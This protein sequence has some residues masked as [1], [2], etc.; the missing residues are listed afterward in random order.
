MSVAQTHNALISYYPIIANTN[1]TSE[2]KYLWITKIAQTNELSGPTYNSKN[3]RHFYP[4]SYGPGD[5]QI[6]GV[7]Q[8]QEDYQLISRFIRKH[9][10]QMVSGVKQIYVDQATIGSYKYLMNLIIPSENIFVQGWI[11]SF[12]INKKGVFDP[13]PEYTFPFTIGWDSHSTNIDSSFSIE[14]WYSPNRTDQIDPSIK[15]TNPQEKYA[16]NLLG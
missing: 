11:N 4:R 13:A 8:S 1:N 6:T 7:A 15:I 3:T 12:T 2:T 16:R 5:Y 14:K 10:E 9:Q